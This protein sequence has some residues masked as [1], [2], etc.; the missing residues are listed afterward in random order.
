VDE[1]TAVIHKDPIPPRRL[2][3]VVSPEL[4]AI[5]LKAM[6][7]DRNRRY[8]SARA[9]AEDLQRYVEGEPVQARPPNLL[10]VVMKRL[11]KHRAVAIVAGAALVM[12]AA[13]GL[14]LISLQR[15]VGRHADRLRELARQKEADAAAAPST[16]AGQHRRAEALLDR[17]RAAGQPAERVSLA[18][19][20]LL[21]DEALEPA[22]VVRAEAYEALGSLEP[23][24]ADFGH[25]ARLSK[26]PLPYHVR[27]ASIAR[28][29][30]RAEDEIEDLSRALGL[31][32]RNASLYE[33]RGTAHFVAREFL[34]AARDWERAVQFD[35]TLK[36]TL[37]PR[38]KQA[39]VKATD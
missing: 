12:L 18:S 24:Y 3:P 25:A 20:A 35:E 39:R 15:E 9:L 10:R 26:R 7:K 2:N 14:V 38:I 29:L 22:Y 13:M 17:A 5:C 34:E 30:D 36:P 31:D 21:L 23:A 8:E 16:E 11:R 32:P 1:A 6:E 33:L 19:Q 37:E 4:E 27:R 28:R